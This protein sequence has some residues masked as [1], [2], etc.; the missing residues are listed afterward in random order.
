[1]ILFRKL[2]YF[3]FIFELAC[4]GCGGNSP[5]T[6]GESIVKSPIV[7]NPDYRTQGT[8]V[9]DMVEGKLKSSTG[10][11]ISYTFLKAKDVSID[12]LVVLG[13]GFMR[14]KA[15]MQYLAHHLASWG[16][17]V[18]NVEFCNSKLWAGNHDLNGADMAA[19]ARKI[20][21]GKV[22]YTG[23]SA[24]GLAALAA[25][26]LDQNTLAYFGLDMVDNQDLGLK[27][28]PQ[29]AVPLYGLYSLPS[30]C[31]A[32]NNGLIS[33][34]LAAHSKVLKIEDSSHCH[35]E[36]PV[37]GKCSFVCGRGEK[38]FNRDEIQQTILG[39]TTAFLLWQ[40]GIDRNGETWWSENDQNFQT[41]LEAGYIRQPTIGEERFNR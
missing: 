21:N 19:V 20:H 32:H 24:G 40:T 38:R 29:S 17:S 36:F 15:R 27:L 35:F 4:T 26:T 25:A 1:M 12:V 37:D 31:N 41:L 8:V 5:N 13:H 34:A 10:C 33:Y 2:V 30:A 6:T 22:I 11:E 28:A 23:F 9:Y 7:L 39:L 18:A 16:L 3:I 14:S